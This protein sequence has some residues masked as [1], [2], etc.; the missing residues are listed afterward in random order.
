M[1]AQ[2]STTPA[3]LRTLDALPGPRGWPLIGN[4]LEV[5]L[6]RL[7]LVLERWREQH[8]DLYQARLGPIRLLVVS[9]PELYRRVFLD[10]PERFRRMHSME[11][12]ARELGMHGLFSA[13][14]A[15]WKRQRKLILPAFRD[16]NLAAAFPV[17][18]MITE[19]LVHLFEREA[20]RGEPI[21]VLHHL[22]R[23]TV[24]VMAA[25]A[26]GLDMNTLEGGRP[27]G[28]AQLQQHFEV[29]FPMILRRVNAPFPYW[30]YFKLGADSALDRA[31]VG[32]R[33]LV[34]PIV[35]NARAELAKDPSAQHRTLLHAM[36]ATADE[37]DGTKLS[38][39]ELVANVFTLLLAGEDTTANTLAWMFYFLAGHPEAQAKVLAEAQSVL[40][41][42]TTLSAHADAGKLRAVGAAAHETLRMKSPAPFISLEAT[43]DTQVG[44]VHVP[45][46]TAVFVLTRPAAMH[47]DN[48]SAPERFQ[49]E[50][51]LGADGEAARDTQDKLRSSLP[52]GAGPRVCPGRQLALLE[53]A[54][55]MS[56]V[57]KRFELS[58]PP[59][60]VV[61][62][63]FDFAMEP[64]GLR[65]TMRAR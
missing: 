3:S 38:N 10:R 41:D 15:D 60:L 62:E 30:R 29:I 51:W 23:Y 54:L 28:T 7:H 6:P 42:G 9:D 14:G 58:L 52:F 50:R 33:T 20:A 37:S 31:L 5:E 13:E 39:E 53:C 11:E 19:R 16:E 32:A 8:G 40:G 26:F 59:G 4:L 48:F 61:Q 55:S 12:V 22:M 57:V 49:L 43:I 24:D 56:A 45:R 25:V 46:G 18:R 47:A 36:I 44:D 34:L 64:E 63:R 1:T 65:V 21:D 2:A 17:L 27:G 35:E